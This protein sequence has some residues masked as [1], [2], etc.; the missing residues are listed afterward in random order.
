METLLEFLK[1]TG[2]RHH[3]LG[4]EVV[5]VWTASLSTQD[6]YDLFHLKDYYVASAGEGP[7]KYL[8]KKETD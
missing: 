8:T 5:Q 6:M 3:Q 4:K 2:V 7:S 1:R